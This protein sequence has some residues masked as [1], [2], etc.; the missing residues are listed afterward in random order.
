MK[1]YEKTKLTLEE[2]EQH[3]TERINIQEQFALKSIT[4]MKRIYD[5]TNKDNKA[6]KEYIINEYIEFF[7]NKKRIRQEWAI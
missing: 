5:E 6:F 2:N 3:F 4:D 7:K 1:R